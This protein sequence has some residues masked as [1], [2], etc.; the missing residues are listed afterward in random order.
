[1]GKRSLVAAFGIALLLGSPALAAGQQDWARCRGN[2]P[3]HAIPSCSHI[4][5]DHEETAQNRAEA[6]LRRAG[7]SLAHGDLDAAIA[8]DGEA[9]K[10]APLNIAAYVDQALAYFRKG[11]R[12]R[13]VVDFAIAARLDAKKADEVA[14]ANAAFARIASIARGS[15]PAAAEANAAAST[16]P[17]C[18]TGETAR[19][20]FVLVNERQLRK[21]QVNPSN[22]DVATNEYFVDG[23][24]SMTA[25]YYKGLLIVFASFLET[26]INSYDIDYTRL[27]VYQVGQETRYH[28]SSVTLAGKVTNVAVERRVA[29]QEKLVIGDCTFDTFV[30]QS[31]TKFPDGTKTVARSNFSPELKTSLRFTTT[32]EGSDPYEVSYNRIEPLSR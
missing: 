31:Q 28:A 23:E 2:D 17:F 3:S 1:M 25:T 12:D 32:T 27:G 11:D 14:A 18:P 15:S 5:A 4:I 10:L 19:N 21:Q 6:Y 13:A 20:G 22:G 8:D 24:R 26:Y 7:A 9:I 16:G 29:G 30:I